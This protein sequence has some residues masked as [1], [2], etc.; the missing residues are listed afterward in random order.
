MHHSLRLYGK[1]QH[2]LLHLYISLAGWS[3]IPVIGWVVRGVANTYA[4]FGHSG[5]Y[6]ALSEAEKIV[7]LSESVALGPC[8]C[9]Q[10][11]HNCSHTIMSE[12]VLSQGSRD[13]YSS[14][15]KE[16]RPITKEA[17]KAVLRQAQSE[18]L[19]HSIMRCGKNF[20]AICNCCSCCCV[21][22][23]LRSKYG[24]GLAL[25]KNPQVVADFEHR[26]LS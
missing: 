25:V 26:R 9:R 3:R 11:F 1:H 22:T 21:P 12:I 7:D 13:V 19:T 15:Q 18:K 16:F 10:E 14:R 6:L 4:R 23:R 17:A 5:Y 2:R 8:S 20:Y 24:I